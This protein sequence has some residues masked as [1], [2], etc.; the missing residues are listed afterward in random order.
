VPDV[1]VRGIAA[2]LVLLAVGAAEDAVSGDVEE[3]D[4]GEGWEGE[5]LRRRGGGYTGLVRSEK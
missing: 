3:G 4:E 5:V 1:G 2:E